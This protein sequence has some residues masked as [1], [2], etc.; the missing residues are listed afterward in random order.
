MKAAIATG[1]GITVAEVPEPVPGPG[2]VLAAPR[3]EGHPAGG[4]LGA[5]L[6]DQGE[7]FLRHST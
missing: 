7:G 4:A 2:Q 6:G 5:C 3:I 1:T